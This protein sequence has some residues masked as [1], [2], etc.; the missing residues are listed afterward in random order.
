MAPTSLSHSQPEE[1]DMQRIRLSEWARRQGISHI[2]AYRMLRRR[3]LPVPCE[4]SPTGRWYVLL[5][6]KRLERAAIYTRAA[7]GPRQVDEINEQ[8]VRLSEWASTRFRS[9]FTI[10]RE[11]ADPYA[12][13]MPRLQR[14]LADRQITNILIQHPGIIGLHNYDLLV[15]A[16]APDGRTILALDVKKAKVASQRADIQAGIVELCVELHGPQRGQ[17][18]ARTAILGDD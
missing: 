17:K 12:S 13:P 4:R 9:I 3:M 7:P 11:I 8:I 15:A 1:G 5:P 2:T 14:L 16:L 6:P 18:I 10:V